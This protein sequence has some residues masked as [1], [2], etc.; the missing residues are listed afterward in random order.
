[1]IKSYKIRLYPTKEQEEKMWKHVGSCRYIWNY[2]LALQQSRHEN[3]EK[4]LSRFDMIKCLTPLKKEN[5]HQWLKDV[6]NT[7]LQ[8]VCTDLSKAYDKFFNK[9]S[10]HPKFKSRKKSKPTFPTRNDN[11]WF[12]GT[13]VNIEKIGKIKYK[14]DFEI[15]LGRGNKFANPRVSYKNGKWLLSFGMECEN[16]APVLTDKP[17]GIDLGIKETMT[18]AYGNDSIVFHNINKSRSVRLLKKQIKHLQRSISRKYEQNRQGRK[19][20]KTR[21]I[22]RAEEK[23]RKLYA[24]LT[25]IRNNYNHQCTHKLVSLLPSR[26]VMEDLNVQ[27]MMKNKHL[28]KAISEQCFF[29]IIGQMKYKC[30]WNNIPFYQVD[31]FYPSSKTCSCCGCIKTNLKLSDRTYQCSECGL[32]ID[33]DLNAAINLQRYIG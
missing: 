9:L 10:R 27:G 26:V 22:E 6:A 8:I 24:R 5:E 31:R 20:I 3:G 28:S 18:V 11:L 15:P 32:V 1:M 16:Q 2:M 7:S 13:Q 21:N 30:E 25:N 4:H 33:R 29:E 17:M 12:D 23:L 14:T 19:F